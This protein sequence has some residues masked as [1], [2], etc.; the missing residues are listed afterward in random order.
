VPPNYQLCRCSP[1][2]YHKNVNVPTKTNKKIKKKK[3][4]KKKMNLKKFS[5]IKICPYKFR[6]KKDFF[7]MIEK[8]NIFMNK[9]KKKNEKNENPRGGPY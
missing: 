9:N 8:K 3:Q 2:N 7:L 1:P 5:I 6:K 4:N